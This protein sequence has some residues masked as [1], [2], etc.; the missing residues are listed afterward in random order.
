MQRAICARLGL[1]C[2]DLQSLQRCGVFTTTFLV[3]SCLRSLPVKGNIDADSFQSLTV[4]RQTRL[5]NTRVSL[6]AAVESFGAQP[7]TDVN[8]SSTGAK[9]NGKGDSVSLPGKSGSK[10]TA[11]HASSSSAPPYADDTGSDASPNGD[12]GV[13]SVLPG[14]NVG[15][16][17]SVRDHGDLSSPGSEEGEND[18]RD[19]SPQPQS[20]A[21]VS[22]HMSPDASADDQTTDESDAQVRIVEQITLSAPARFRLSPRLH[23][24][25]EILGSDNRRS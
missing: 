15:N 6:V 21:M 10:A 11:P 12:T 23:M 20:P 7:N 25:T 18:Q 9:G 17:S 1:L 4:P 16:A 19:R 22:S 3:H 5:S 2:P 14:G 13:D 8:S 24:Q